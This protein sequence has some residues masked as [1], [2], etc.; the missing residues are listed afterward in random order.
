MP[1]ARCRRWRAAVLPQS[2]RA[3]I[4]GSYKIE[5]HGG[6]A[7]PAR[8]LQRMYAHRPCHPALTGVCRDNIT[9][10]RNV[11]AATA[12][13]GAQVIGAD[14]RPPSS[15]TNTSLPDARQWQ[16]R[17]A[18]NVARQRVCLAGAK[19]G[20][21]HAPNGI[22]VELCS[23]A[24]YAGGAHDNRSVPGQ[25]AE[26]SQRSGVGRQAI[27][28]MAVITC[29]LMRPSIGPLP[30]RCT[31]ASA[32]F[33]VASSRRDGSRASISF[34]SGVPWQ[35]A[36]ATSCGEEALLLSTL[37][38]TEIEVKPA[39]SSSSRIGSTSK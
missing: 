34:L 4:A 1:R 23:G 31:S 18:R 3:L 33:C 7:T 12:I 32:A 25:N 30:N 16:T 29:A 19:D 35:K 10:I 20:L 8:A 21:D 2:Y 6:E 37:V 27:H 11:A 36:I 24:D 15:A 14:A 28:R 22:I 38:S 39:L 5:L 26:P 9:A 17:R 13:V